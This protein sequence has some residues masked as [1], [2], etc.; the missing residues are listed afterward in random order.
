M[1]GRLV[2]LVGSLWS[3]LKQ[4]KSPAVLLNIWTKI[5]PEQ[6]KSTGVKDK[7][8]RSICAQMYKP[9]YTDYILLC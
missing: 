2:G 9:V 8:Y 4:W 1:N 7:K 5:K 3:A 6:D